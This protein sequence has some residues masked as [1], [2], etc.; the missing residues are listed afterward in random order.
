MSKHAMHKILRSAAI[1]RL[2]PEPIARLLGDMMPKL[3]ASQRS[4]IRLMT[5]MRAKYGEGFKSIPAV[6]DALK[7]FDDH[8]EFV[9][10]FI[11]IRG[12][13]RG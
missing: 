8:R 6:E 11:R 7:H 1:P 12:K 2:D 5:A 3:D 9:R 13:I 4:R 10:E